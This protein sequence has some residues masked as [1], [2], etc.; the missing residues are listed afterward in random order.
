MATILQNATVRALAAVV[1]PG[2]D[3]QKKEYD[4]VVPLQLTGNKT[5]LFCVHAG[6]GEILIFLNL[7]NYFAG[8]RPFYA[9][10]ARGF[11]EGESSFA[12]FDEMVQ[13]YVAAIRRRQPHGPYAIAGYSYGGPVAFEIAKA[14]EAQGERVAFLASID[15]T[16]YIGLP[17]ARLD[18][19]D[20]AVI[21][22]FFLSLIDVGQ[23]RDLARQ[24]RD[25]PPAQDPYSYLISIAPPDRL[26]ALDLDVQKFKAWAE[27]SHELVQIGEAY[28]PSGTSRSVTVFYAQPLS[29]TKEDW[30]R[31]QL[32]QWDR[33]TREPNRYIEVDGE[34]H[35]IFAP[36]HLAHFQAVLRAE[37]NR[38]GI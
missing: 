11:N 38:E 14:L 10:R 15:G 27:L 2:A 32:K 29:G 18:A 23:M 36:R 5:P 25:T 17:D 30:L 9:L 1:A 20:S 6:S 19:I 35:T 28:V 16:P 7:A 3:G 26:K 4:P 37:I 31:S 13:T 24:L 21:L 22:A 12:S 34:H 8:E 33:Y